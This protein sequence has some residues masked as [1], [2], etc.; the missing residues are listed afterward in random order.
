[1]AAFVQLVGGLATPESDFRM[2]LWSTL[3]TLRLARSVV[4][5]DAVEI[6]PSSERLAAALGV[7]VSPEPA[8]EP[9]EAR[10]EPAGT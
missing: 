4:T 5:G 10:E 1:M 7:S 8:S 6:A 9:S 3:A 2:S